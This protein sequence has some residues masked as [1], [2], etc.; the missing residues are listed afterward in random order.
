MTY[1]EMCMK[2][3]ADQKDWKAWLERNRKDGGKE[4]ELLGLLPEEYTD[5][6]NGIRSFGFYVFK[7]R[8]PRSIFQLWSGCYVKY[9]FEHEGSE[10]HF[11]CGW[12]DGVSN[13][14]GFCNIQCDDGFHGGRAVT[15]R[16]IDVME[17]LPYKERY[18]IYYK[19]MM[20]GRCDKCDHSSNEEPRIDCPHYEFMNAVLNKQ[21]GDSE[22]LK[23]YNGVSC[24]HDCGECGKCQ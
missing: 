8:H 20:C 13:Q 7:R 16:T 19:T 2:G 12:V 23:L 9:L 5:L 14:Q 18:L 4:N 6:M 3:E 21:R 1:I 22:F 11:E 10:P 15:V 24:Q 17:V